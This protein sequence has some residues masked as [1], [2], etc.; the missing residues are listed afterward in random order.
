M[1]I[2]DEQLN[3]LAKRITKAGRK[4]ARDQIAKIMHLEDKEYNTIYVVS[5]SG[6]EAIVIGD[7]RRRSTNGFMYLYWNNTPVRNSYPATKEVATLLRR[8][9]NRERLEEGEGKADYNDWPEYG[10][11]D[12]Q[13]EYFSM[14][15]SCM[16]AIS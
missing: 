1:D 6:F 3:E 11:I 4:I 2:T 15:V 16:A 5:D 12:K 13:L 8:V 14:I 7:T 10:G 9:I